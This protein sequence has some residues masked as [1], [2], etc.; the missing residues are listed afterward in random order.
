MKSILMSFTNYAVSENEKIFSKFGE[1]SVSMWQCDLSELIETQNPFFQKFLTGK[2]KNSYN[3][4]T[5]WKN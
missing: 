3:G 5:V 2:L 1:F 4:E